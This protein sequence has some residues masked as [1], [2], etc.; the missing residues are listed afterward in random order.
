MI[1]PLKR[2]KEKPVE[3][4]EFILQAIQEL[5]SRMDANFDRIDD[6]LEKIQCAQTARNEELAV[7]KALFD[8]HIEDQKNSFENQGKRIGELEKNPMVRVGFALGAASL[9]LGVL[10]ALFSMLGKL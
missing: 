7:L 1:D 9:L 10:V 4:E 5:R 3:K 6:T 8:S 2:Y